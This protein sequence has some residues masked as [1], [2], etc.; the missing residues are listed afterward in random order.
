MECT[1]VYADVGEDRGPGDTGL[2]EEPVEDSLIKWR[3]TPIWDNDGE[4]LCPPHLLRVGQVSRTGERAMADVPK[5]IG[6]AFN[7]YWREP[8]MTSLPARAGIYCV[9]TCKYNH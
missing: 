8:K 2:V 7:R 5:T 3:D 6:L 9:Y 4:K 1:P